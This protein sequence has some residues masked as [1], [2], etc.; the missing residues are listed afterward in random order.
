MKYIHSLYP[1]HIEHEQNDREVKGEHILKGSEE[2][3]KYNG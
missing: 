3:E 2:K 1:A